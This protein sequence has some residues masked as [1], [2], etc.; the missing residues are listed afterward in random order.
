[1]SFGRRIRVSENFSLK[2]QDITAQH[3][4]QARQAREEARERVRV[5]QGGRRGAAGGPWITNHT[6]PLNFQQ[7]SVLKA[8]SVL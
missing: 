5:P 7:F 8:G 6:Q 3:E 4:R 2:S 1:M